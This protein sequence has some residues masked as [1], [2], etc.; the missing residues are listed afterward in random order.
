MLTIV[1]I[2]DNV[3]VKRLSFLEVK[4]LMELVLP[5]NYVALDE[6]EMMYLDGGETGLEMRR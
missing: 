2:S 6:E 1:R 3:N 4:K 5:N